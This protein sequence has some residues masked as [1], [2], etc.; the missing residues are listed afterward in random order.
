MVWGN[1]ASFD[2][3]I[4]EACYKAVGRKA[5]WPY[6]A[7]MCYR[8]IKN[9]NKDC[10][11]ALPPNNDSHHNAEADALWQAQHLMNLANLGRVTL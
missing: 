11:E 8:T 1:G 4:L 6:Y 5:P 10:K 3:P 7:A 9:L 2:Q